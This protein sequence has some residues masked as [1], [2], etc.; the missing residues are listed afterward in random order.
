MRHVVT[1]KG[2]GFKVEGVDAKMKPGLVGMNAGDE[3]QLCVDVS[4]LKHQHSDDFAQPP[5]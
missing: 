1:S 3:V 2:F 4:K 5:T